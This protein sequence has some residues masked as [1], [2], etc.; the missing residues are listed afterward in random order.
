MAGNM[1]HLP[2]SVSIEQALLAQPLHCTPAQPA[3][4]RQTTFE[5]GISAQLSPEPRQLPSYNVQLPDNNAYCR[6]PR[7]SPLLPGWACSTA[8]MESVAEPLGFLAGDDFVVFRVLAGE[9]LVGD[10]VAHLGAIDGS[11]SG[12]M[13]L[14]G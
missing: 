13:V 12:K 9:K 3:I 8:M 14:C 4:F 5:A 2:H 6:D 11:L 1:L 7:P 10:V